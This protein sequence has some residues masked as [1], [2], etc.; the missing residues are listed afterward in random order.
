[1]SFD[2]ESRWRSNCRKNATRRPDTPAGGRS[3]P[4]PIGYRFGNRTATACSGQPRPNRK[5]YPRGCFRPTH[6]WRHASISSP[7]APGRPPVVS[8]LTPPWTAQGSWFLGRFNDLEWPPFGFPGN[9]RHGP[10]G[11]VTLRTV[12]P[13][14]RRERPGRR[15]PDPTATNASH[16]RQTPEPRRGSQPTFTQCLL[17][18]LA[19]TASQT[20]WVSRESRKV[21]AQG[22]P[23]A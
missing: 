12:R 23:C 9:S 6:R 7:G 8:P 16:F 20:F 17:L 15:L 11:D 14:G 13:G 2:A 18:A 5:R 21:G 19:R 10:A 3:L 4:L 1:M 22:L